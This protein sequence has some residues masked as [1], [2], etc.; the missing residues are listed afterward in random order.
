MSETSAGRGNAEKG[1]YQKGFPR[2][3]FFQKGFPQKLREDFLR[4]PFRVLARPFKTFDALKYEKE[5]SYAFC[6][7]VLV[8]SSLINILNFVYEGF[9]LNHN[10]PYSISSLYLALATLFPTA[11][12]VTGNWCVTTLMDG[13]GRFGE[14]FQVTMYA[15]F[16]LCLMQLLA[17]ALSNVLTLEEIVA[18]GAVRVIGAG[19]FFLYLF[20][21]LT[22][23]HEYSFSR[24]LGSLVLTLVAMMVL[25][26][27]LML[28]F[29]L[30]ADVIDFFRVVFKELMLKYF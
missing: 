20:M 25:V 9:L 21:G 16:P 17:L 6:V 15:L 11:L 30:S 19:M 4:F 23:V 7:F 13:K 22:V 24:C 14:I 18:V 26:F 10:D 1:F 5:G 29:T 8:L 27:I 2:K 12:F 3:G 28:L